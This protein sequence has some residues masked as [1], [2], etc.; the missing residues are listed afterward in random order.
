MKTTIKF[1]CLSILLFYGCNKT[2]ESQNEELILKETFEEGQIFFGFNSAENAIKTVRSKTFSGNVASKLRFT[3][4]IE[5]TSIKENAASVLIS[6]ND[7]SDNAVYSSEVIPLVRVEE[8]ILSLPLSFSPGDYKITLFQV[9][10]ASNTAIAMTPQEDSPLSG[11]V[12]DSLE[13]DFSVASDTTERINLEVLPTD[14]KSAE[15]FGYSTFSFTEIKLFPFLMGVFAY[16]TTTNNFEL[17]TASISIKHLEHNKTYYENDYDS[18][19][20][21]F[22]IPETQEDNVIEIV[23]SKEGFQTQTITATI[24]ELKEYFDPTPQGK[25]PMIVTL[26]K[27]IGGVT[28]DLVFHYDAANSD[29]FSS[30]EPKVWKDLSG[31]NHNAKIN[32]ANYVDE[33]GGGLQSTGEDAHYITVGSAAAYNSISE[34]TLEAWVK[35]G[36][37]FGLNNYQFIFSNTRD[38]CGSYN[39]YSLLFLKDRLAFQI[40]KKAKHKYYRSDKDGFNK[41][42][43]LYHVMA[44]YDGTYVKLY[45]D[46]RLDSSHEVTFEIGTPGR[47]PLQIGNMGG[48]PSWFRNNGTYYKL[49]IYNRALTESEV[50]RN[51]NTSKSRFLD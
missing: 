20:L 40:N 47:F 50:L 23:V 51:Y 2:S 30:S 35:R 48:S 39:G 41:V 25:G 32:Y 13:I 16:D 27:A 19:T 8:D 29:S 22:Q 14:Q 15:D 7:D 1:L 46:G 33:Y 45:I 43:E 11:L 10:D 18:E 4:P 38:C 49:R 17:T 12:S 31:N 26:T 21:T 9:L 34:L 3:S 28:Q 6:I 5:L 24:A 37:H 42:G 36:K 44:T